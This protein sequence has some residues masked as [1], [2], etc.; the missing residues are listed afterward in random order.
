MMLAGFQKASCPPDV[1]LVVSPARL[2]HRE[3]GRQVEHDVRVPDGPVHGG[4]VPDVADD[5]IDGPCQPRLVG[6]LPVQD[7]DGHALILQAPHELEAQEAG[8]SGH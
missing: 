3:D 7:A 2:G 4:R 8:T 5:K 6:R 1:D